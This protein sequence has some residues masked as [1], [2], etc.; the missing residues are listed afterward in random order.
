MAVLATAGSYTVEPL[1]VAVTPARIRTTVEL[2]SVV[3]IA[4]SSVTPT[5]DNSAFGSLTVT[6]LGTSGR[7]ARRSVDGSR[8]CRQCS[9]SGKTRITGSCAN[10][11]RAT[12][13]LNK[14]V[15]LSHAGEA[16]P[17]VTWRIR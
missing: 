4:S 5:A 13:T 17:R 14:Q 2:A 1:G 7:F 12:S 8:Q 3:R 11:S 10:A 6:G 16:D 15:T 9:S